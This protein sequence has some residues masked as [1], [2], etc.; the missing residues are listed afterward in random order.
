MNSWNYLS[1]AVQRIPAEFRNFKMIQGEA[2]QRLETLL[3][4]NNSLLEILE[5]DN[6]SLRQREELLTFRVSRYLP[7][8]SRRGMRRLF[9]VSGMKKINT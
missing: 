5:R 3:A 2:L 1:D 4:E 8:N 7:I 9:R 6:R